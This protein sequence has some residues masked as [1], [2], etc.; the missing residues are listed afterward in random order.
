VAEDRHLSV[1]AA[2]DE[3]RLFVGV[4]LELGDVVADAEEDLR[5]GDQISL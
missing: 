4:P 3:D 1:H 5:Q 2:A